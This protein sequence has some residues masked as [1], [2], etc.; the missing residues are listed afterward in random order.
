MLPKKPFLKRVISLA[1]PCMLPKSFSHDNMRNLFLKNLKGFYS[2]TQELRSGALLQF[3]NA[4]F[5]SPSAFVCS[6]W[7]AFQ[8]HR[9]VMLNPDLVFDFV[10]VKP[11]KV[12]AKIVCN[13]HMYLFKS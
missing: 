7:S 6:F 5:C 1:V 12:K 4:V 10:C 8:R 9:C 11:A 3:L 13:F 2:R